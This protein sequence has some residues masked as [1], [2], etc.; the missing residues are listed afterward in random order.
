[1]AE[2]SL[3]TINKHDLMNKSQLCKLSVALNT[4][5]DKEKEWRRKKT[6]V[7]IC[8]EHLLNKCLTIIIYDDLIAS[9]FETHHSLA[10]VR[11]DS[12]DAAEHERWMEK[13][14][15]TNGDGDDDDDDNDWFTLVH[16]EIHKRT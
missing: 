5:H 13:M 6:A 10:L 15:A 12:G 2:K 1:M 11:I 7:Q 3:L 8:A 4:R 14:Q 9:N 16:S